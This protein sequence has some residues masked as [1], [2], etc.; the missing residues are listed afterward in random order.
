M[1]TAYGNLAGAVGI[2]CNALLCAAKLLMGT[3]FGSISV[4]ADAVNNLSDASSSII[5]LVGFKLSAKPADKEHPYGH[6]RIE[7][8]AGLAVSVL[9]IVIGFELARTSLDK[10]LHPTPVAFSWLTVAVLAGSIGVK[11]WMAMFNRTIGRRIGS[12]TL[13]ATATDSR[14]DVIS[15]AAVLAALVL[16]Q[17]THLVLDGWMG[18]AVALFIL[19]SGIGLIKETVDALLGE[20]PSEELAQHIAR[21][22][23][24]YDGVLGT[25]DLMVHDY[26]PGR[27]FASVHVEMAAEKDVL[28]SH[29]IIDNI[30]RDFHDNDNIHLVI[31]YD[32]IQTGDRAVGTLRA[33][34]EGQL[35]TISPQLSMHD[36]RTVRG[37]THTNLIFDVVVPAGFALDDAA[38]R[39][40]IQQLAQQKN[41]QEMKYYTVVT[42]DHSYAPYHQDGDE[43]KA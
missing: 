7:Y 35:K 34:V 10:I 4:T 38:L 28:E 23:L 42:V 19:Y 22:V 33:W 37:P 43:P 31:H 12:A 13:E 16:G 25:H 27:C 14:N 24:S 8:L 40:R 32:P 41:T 15:T 30:E 21:K 9:I 1:R 11:L 17:A 26:G 29:D 18:L 39:A 3:L 2:V 6:A 20:A 5:T 36:F